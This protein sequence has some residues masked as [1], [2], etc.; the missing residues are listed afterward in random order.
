MLYTL[1][2]STCTC[3]CRCARKNTHAHA[4]AHA[5]TD[6]PADPGAPDTR[7]RMMHMHTHPTAPSTTLSPVAHIWPHATHSTESP[8]PAATALH[9]SRSSLNKTWLKW[10][11]AD[12]SRAQCS[13]YLSG[14]CA[15]RVLQRAAA[16][17]AGCELVPGAAARAE[18]CG[19]RSRHVRSGRCPADRLANKT[20][21]TRPGARTTREGLPSRRAAQALRKARSA[22]ALAPVAGHGG[23]SD[24]RNS[25]ADADTTSVA[26]ESADSLT[27]ARS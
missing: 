12:A 4:H 24:Q 23:R 20:H 7:M 14:E 21:G 3:K 15:R 22:Q 17:R 1:L 10:R 27:G 25:P 13:R 18:F 26:A 11:G 9:T 6:A 2:P 8:Q 16:A 19:A 5:D